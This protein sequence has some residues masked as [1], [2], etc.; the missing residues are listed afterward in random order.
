ML[1]P[2]SFPCSFPLIDVQIFTGHS[3]QPWFIPADPFVQV[4]GQQSSASARFRKN[5]AKLQPAGHRG[6]GWYYAFFWVETLCKSL[7][8]HSCQYFLHFGMVWSCLKIC[9]KSCCFN[10]GG[11]PIFFSSW[12]IFVKSQVCLPAAQNIVSLPHFVARCSYPCRNTCRNCGRWSRER[13]WFLESGDRAGCFS[14][15]HWHG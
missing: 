10:C 11:Y 2:F 4:Y 5:L 12:H 13:L 9:A 7:G 8:I 6:N 1:V 3:T 14:W 15:S